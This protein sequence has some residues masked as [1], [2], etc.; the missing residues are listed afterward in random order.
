MIVMGKVFTEE[1]KEKMKLEDDKWRSMGSWHLADLSVAIESTPSPC[2]VSPEVV[3][4][5]AS[6]MATR[7]SQRILDKRP[8][9]HCHV[10]EDDQPRKKSRPDDLR[11]SNAAYAR[12]L[13]TVTIYVGDEQIPFVLHLG[14]LR[15]RCP[16]LLEVL[17]QDASIRGNDA[18][19]LPAE[20]ERTFRMFQVW[21]Y[22]GELIEPTA[23]VLGK[24]EEEFEAQKR[25]VTRLV[26]GDSK[27]AESSVKWLDEDLI[28]LYLLGRRFKLDTLCNNIINE[29][30]AEHNLMQCTTSLPAIKKAFAKS[31]HLSQFL[32]HEADYRLSTDKLNIPDKVTE[33]PLEYVAGILRQILER[34]QASRHGWSDM[35]VVDNYWQRVCRYHNNCMRG[36]VLGC[37]EHWIESWQQRKL[38][39]SRKQALYTRLSDVG[40]VVVGPEQ[41]PFTVHIRLVSA[42]SEFFRGA[43]EGRFE[44]GRTGRVV[45]EDD[46]PAEFAMMLHWL[47][48]GDVHVPSKDDYDF[49]D[50]LEP[51][52]GDSEAEDGSSC[53]Y[54]PNPDHLRGRFQDSLVGLYI[55]ADKRGVQRLKNDILTQICDQKSR[56]WPL[57]VSSLE[58]ISMACDNLPDQDPLRAW[59]EQEASRHWSRSMNLS[60][61]DMQKL[62]PDFLA[63]VMHNMLQRH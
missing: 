33:Y 50:A 5:V 38:N 62:P 39:R 56:G 36:T 41:V 10:R 49:L 9:P 24:S 47:Y 31:Q 35:S 28:D 18:F 57:L 44:E 13:D 15:E 63:N 2:T 25:D 7:S 19:E 51:H 43:F 53:V 29:L 52:V 8:I 21:L 40:T 27:E 26:V 61:S 30:W 22:T 12:Y 14:I 37:E 55:L 23:D 1:L 17:G 32:I 58:R 16:K 42:F 4:R 3:W 59:L 34:Q 46:S 60:R 11:E 54:P 20:E 48:T 6:T 45:L